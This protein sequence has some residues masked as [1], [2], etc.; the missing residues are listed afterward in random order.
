MTKSIFTDEYKIFQK[1]LLTERK[2]K[3]LSQADLGNLLVK[4]QSFVYKY[5]NAERRLDVVE[6]REIL[7]VLDVDFISFMREFDMKCDEV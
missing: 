7:K 4:P 3:G 1:L 2:K 6:V 5:E